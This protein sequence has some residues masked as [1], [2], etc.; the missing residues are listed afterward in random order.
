MVKLKNVQAYPIKDVPDHLT[1]ECAMLGQSIIIELV[2]MLKDKDP[3]I[4]LGAFSFVFASMIKKL[5]SND[6]EQLR[7]A[8]KLYALGLIKNVEHLANIKVMDDN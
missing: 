4:I 3:N 1:H 8:C 7:S 5:V 2:P 6:P